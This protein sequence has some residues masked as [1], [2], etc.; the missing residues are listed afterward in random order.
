M[1]RRQSTT[2]RSGGSAVDCGKAVKTAWD[3]EGLE[4]NTFFP[5]P[6]SAVF[7][8]RVGEGDTAKADSKRLAG[9][10]G[11]LARQGRGKPTYGNVT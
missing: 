7:A 6:A 5:I 2:Q 8:R 11:T 1:A 9:V 3:L 10:S 4:P